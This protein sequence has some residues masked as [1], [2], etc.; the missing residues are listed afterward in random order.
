MP[1]GLCAVCDNDLDLSDAGICKTC[2][3]GFC[4]SRC[5]TWHA[6]QHACH[7]CVPEDHCCP[8]C[9]DLECDTDCGERAEI[10]REHLR[11]QLLDIQLDDY[12]WEEASD[13]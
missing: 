11:K 2:G 10:Y 4:W 8:H 7:N 9:G 13:A 12:D 5:G 6:G 1:I 3:Q